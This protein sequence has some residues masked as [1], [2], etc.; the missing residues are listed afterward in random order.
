MSKRNNCL[1]KGKKRSI[2]REAKMR[3]KMMRMRSVKGEMMKQ[4]AK[5]PHILV[6]SSKLWLRSPGPAVP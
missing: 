4:E 2:S 1:S 5:K 6:E 3:W